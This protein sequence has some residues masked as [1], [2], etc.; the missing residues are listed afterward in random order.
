V[1]PG[2]ANRLL[3][4]EA[5][6]LLKQP[7]PDHTTVHRN[8]ELWEINATTGKLGRRAQDGDI[9]GGT[10]PDLYVWPPLTVPRNKSY[11]LFVNMNTSASGGGGYFYYIN[12]KILP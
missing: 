7:T 3:V 2:H 5:E 9:F 4:S 6:H 10:A 8:W 12:K 11:V 1:D